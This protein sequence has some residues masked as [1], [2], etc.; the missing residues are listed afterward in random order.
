MNRFVKRILL[1]V[2]AGVVAGVYAWPPA[3]VAD[4]GAAGGGELRVHSGF[5]AHSRQ[6][7]TF[8]GSQK[9]WFERR[10]Q[11]V[12]LTVEARS[13]ETEAGDTVARLRDGE[14]TAAVLAASEAEVLVPG[15]VAYGRPLLFC[16]RPEIAALRARFDEQLLAEV[17]DDR[18]RALHVIGLDGVHLLAPEPLARPGDVGDR[19]AWIPRPLERLQAHFVDLGLTVRTFGGLEPDDAVVP[20]TADDVQVNMPIA[21]LMDRN[22]PR[23]RYVSEQP[24][25]Y[26]YFLVLADRRQLDALAAP[27]RADFLDYLRQIAARLED[28]HGRG[29]Q[30]AFDLLVRQGMAPVTLGGGWVHSAN[31][32][33]DSSGWADAT[34]DA[35]LDRLRAEQPELCPFTG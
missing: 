25:S 10:N 17:S 4:A 3:G 35:E 19:P 14:L 16:S 1:V 29:A 18:F 26:T 11:G 33:T 22:L 20:M 30:R 6:H 12:T 13:A 27:Q 32:A 15:A 2:V 9:G 5:P 8:L 23:P 31:A 7:R 21:L 34:L 24:V 28:T